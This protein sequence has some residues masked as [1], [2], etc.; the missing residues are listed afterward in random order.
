LCDG[1]LLLVR[2]LSAPAKELARGDILLINAQPTIVK[3]VI[4]EG[5]DSIEIVGESLKLNGKLVQ[6]TYAC[7]SK[8]KADNRTRMSHLPFTVSRDYLYV[9]GDNRSASQDSRSIGPVSVR[10][11]VARVLFRIPMSRQST[12]CRCESN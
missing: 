5:S 8:T 10:N 3:R 9:M 12:S 2:V 7:F 11:V 1:D 6:E 4:A